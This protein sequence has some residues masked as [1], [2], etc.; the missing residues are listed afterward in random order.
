MKKTHATNILLM[1]GVSAGVHGLAAVV[2][3]PAFAV[4]FLTVGAEP[5]PLQRLL[6]TTDRG[7]T[8]LLAAPLL[9]AA[10][11]FVL[12]AFLA[13]VFTLI[14]AEPER[15]VKVKEQEIESKPAILGAV[16]P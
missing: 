9:W 5:A 11:G 7:M 16:S 4:M 3:M 8:L 14:T 1:A 6:E 13:F 2:V 15:R 12:G 10:V